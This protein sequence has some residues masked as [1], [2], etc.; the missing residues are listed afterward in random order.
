MESAETVKES[1]PLESFP[2]PV[3]A[4][5]SKDQPYVEF[6]KS[7]DTSVKV[8]PEL[9]VSAMGGSKLVNVQD[10]SDIMTPQQYHGLP[11]ENTVVETAPNHESFVDAYP[12]LKVRTDSSDAI[13][14]EPKVIENELQDSVDI[15]PQ[16][17]VLQDISDEPLL[18]QEASDPLSNY[19]NPTD[20]KDEENVPCSSE[21]GSVS[22]QSPQE[23]SLV[24]SSDTQQQNVA[25]IP[26]TVEQDT[27]SA[28]VKEP[29]MVKFE[30]EH[31][32]SSLLIA[33][34]GKPNSQS[35][36][37]E[38]DGSSPQVM[39]TESY[40]HGQ[41]SDGISQA[42]VNPEV[43]YIDTT[44]PF[45]S[46][47]EAVSK[48]GGIV[49]WKAHRVHTVEKRKVIEEELKSVNQEI[50]WLRKQSEAAED[51]KTKVLRELDSTKRLIEELKLN[52]ERAQIEEHQA[53]QDSELASLRVVE[54]E[55][56]IAN[57]VSVAAKAQ[58]EVARSRHVAALSE[59][60]TVKEELSTIRKDYDELVM[61]KNLAVKKAEEALSASKEI[62]KTVEELTIELI[63]TKD[64]LE[65][66]HA[67]HLEAEEHKLGAAMAL[68]Q[69]KLDWEKELKQAEE[70][71]K[72]LDQ[73]ILSAKDLKSEL[74]TASALLRDVKAELAAYMDSKLNKE[75]EEQLNAG[76]IDQEKKTH[77]DIQAAVSS[78]KK[79]LEEVK[80][81]IEKTTDEIKLLEVAAT[82]LK[83]QLE[84]EKSALATLR[85]REG[86]ASV[87]VASIEA[88]LNRT[89]NEIAM[90]QVKEREA[91]EKMVEL[92]KQ[93]QKAAEE[94]DQAKSLAYAAD[95]E[96]RKAQE[97][98]ERAK[99][100]ASTVQSRLLATQKEIEA[101]KASEKLAVA[102][103]NALQES[104]SAQTLNN[105]DT[106]SG[107]TLTLEEYFELSKLA[108]EAEEQANKR[109]V[110]ALSLIETAKESEL[111]SLS[112]LEKITSELAAE[113]DTLQIAREKAEK[114]REG[115]MGI[116]QELRK[117]RAEHE[118]RRKAGESIP[119]AVYPSKSP[120]AS[121]EVRKE[122]NYFDQAPNTAATHYMQSP[123]AYEHSNTETD[124]SPDVKVL[125]KKKR[126]VLPRFLMF[127]TRKKKNPHSR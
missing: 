35:L 105:D 95:E 106:P 29:D 60:E 88:E 4:S 76:V 31:M 44:A 25:D 124:T 26:V 99:A 49:D 70:E 109:V 53:K 51:S 65:S 123:K 16:L 13:S 79:N 126:S 119:G 62:E 114:A 15:Y 68:E 78:A 8:E 116:E 17:K 57:E 6:P 54:M 63:A 59:L 96:L 87:A 47:K 45:E 127:L 121:F 48:F 122:T 34:E 118:Q 19:D 74:D 18:E 46:V 37:L 43:G 77:S 27:S 75:S 64:S 112:K 91:R 7:N 32:E 61:E 14:Y 21:I 83:I 101:A 52:L 111:R 50:P 89:K 23:G 86:M 102:A 22:Q 3:L 82:S 110:D 1:S 12:K 71:L 40:R 90:V 113:K 28:S 11:V 66:A 103:I 72:K 42:L 120:R 24:N 125:K 98:V 92:P 97:E 84:S 5:E 85:Q 30:G 39:G 58:F 38:K 56:G 104:E 2:N 73:K 107:V 55:Q 9:H 69:D 94:A 80:L 93:L 81:N 100:G 41:T 67:A 115:K 10:P 108:H 33:S 20:T 36:L 117:W